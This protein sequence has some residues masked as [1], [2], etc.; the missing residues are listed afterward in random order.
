MHKMW[1]LVQAK[2]WEQKD[3]YTWFSLDNNYSIR[4]VQEIEDVFK[5]GISTV[6]YPVKCI[7]IY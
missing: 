5:K 1:Y 2:I 4:V 7:N 6:K 3:D